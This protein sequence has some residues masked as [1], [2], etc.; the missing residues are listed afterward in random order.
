[1]PIS[2]RTS[3]CRIATAAA[4]AVSVPLLNSATTNRRK[5]RIAITFD[6]E[7]SRNFPTWEQ[8]NWDYEKGNLDDATKRYTVTAAQRIKEAGGVLHGFVV[9]QVLEQADVGWLQTLITDGHLLGNHTYDHVRVTAKLLEEIQFRFKRAPWLIQEKEPIEV[10][11]EN[12]QLCTSAMK[13]RLGHA[14]V[15]FRTPGG[16]S[17]GLTDRSDLQHML[18]N[19]GFKWISSKYASHL[20]GS[21][22][23]QKI[24]DS[25]IQAQARSQPFVYPT[26]LIEIPMSPISD[27]GA[28]RNGRWKLE[29]FME[30]IRLAIQWTIANRAV[31]DFIAH[32]SCLGVID[33]QLKTIDMICR[34][35]NEAGDRA[36]LTDLER[37]SKS[38]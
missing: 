22:P 23:D 35:V 36:E 6:L 37:V 18:L 27:I 31:F 10:I 12:V 28:F 34:L 21:K 11:R 26:G 8:T 17:N 29:W 3:L 20:N 32:P 30:A 14:P 4:A 25:I 19:Q 38:I 1:M 7:M 16:F 13:S 15:G 33:P 24:Y 5:A 2:R 9:G